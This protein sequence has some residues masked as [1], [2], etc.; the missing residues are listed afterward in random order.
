MRC[1]PSSCRVRCDMACRLGLVVG[2]RRRREGV[3][4]RSRTYCKLTSSTAVKEE[5]AMG[6]ADPIDTSQ[7]RALCIPMMLPARMVAHLQACLA[8]RTSLHLS[9][10]Q[11]VQLENWR[12]ATSAT[13]KGSTCPSGVRSLTLTCSQARVVTKGRAATQVHYGRFA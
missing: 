2:K 11:E 4:A 3:S 5:M 10:A 13:S 7:V 9:T 6:I 1:D 12:G 8:C